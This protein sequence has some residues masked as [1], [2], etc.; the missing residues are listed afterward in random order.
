MCPDSE[1]LVAETASA[2]ARDSGEP[3]DGPPI[4]TPSA[5]EDVA[6]GNAHPIDL[7]L[8]IPLPFGRYYIT[9]VAG[10]E[11]RGPK[12]RAEDRL[13]H[14]ILCT[15]N[16]I[17]LFL[18]GSVLGLAALALIQFGTILALEQADVLIGR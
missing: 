18:V 5:P 11:R 4:A 2:E 8:S 1:H 10:R 12:R 13:I 14:P 7:R 15:G 9:L 17:V 16:V 3:Q 6:W